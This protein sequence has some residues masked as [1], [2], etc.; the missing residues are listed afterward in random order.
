MS[1]KSKEDVHVSWEDPIYSSNA[2]I[3]ASGGCLD[4]VFLDVG[5]SLDRGVLSPGENER[6]YRENGDCAIPFYECIFLILGFRLPFND[7]E[8]EVLKHLLVASS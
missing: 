1:Q 2:F 7:F 3:F 8:M 5:P 6:I 4:G